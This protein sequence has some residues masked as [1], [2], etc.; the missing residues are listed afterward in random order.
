MSAAPDPAERA[1]RDEAARWFSARRAGGMSA[2]EIKA[3][4][5][6]KMSVP[7][8]QQAFDRLQRQWEILGQVADD[9]AI[10]DMR[11]HDLRRFDRP[12]RRKTILAIAAALLLSVTSIATLQQYGLLDWLRPAAKGEVFQTGTGQRAVATL[13]DG[14]VVTLDAESEL[15]VVE[16]AAERRL[17][18]VRGHAFFQVAKDPVHPFFVEAAGKS[19]RA[20]GTKFDVRLDD[21][22]RLTV[23]LVEGKVRVEQPTGWL[24]PER[25]ADM[26]AGGQLVARPADRSWNLTQ[27][28]TANDTS[29]LTGRLTFVREPLA[30]AI[31]E[32]NR[33]SKRKIVFADGPIP[34]TDIVGVFAAGDVDSFVTAMEMNEIA[35][36]VDR[37]DT[38]IRLVRDPRR[39]TGTESDPA[40]K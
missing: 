3:F 29:W 4:S 35:R 14:S 28:D 5:A 13:V 24:R 2:A 31:A 27:V 18:L 7:G 36:P 12:A 40:S 10:L 9:P 15:R 33:Y 23:T 26:V 20:V 19:I 39:S 8:A 11:E 30:S 38:E 17:Q 25:R 37:S 22:A 34:D 6:W 1:V 16:M 32:V 21:D